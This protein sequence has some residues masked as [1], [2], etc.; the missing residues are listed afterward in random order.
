MMKVYVCVRQRRVNRK[1]STPADTPPINWQKQQQLN[2]VLC[3]N[4]FRNLHFVAK[5]MVSRP[6]KSAHFIKTT[7]LSDAIDC[8]LQ[9]YRFIQPILCGQ[10]CVV[11]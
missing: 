11:A 8:E 6:L 9:C 4:I 1:K 3:I 2:N 7:Q 10:E 5:L